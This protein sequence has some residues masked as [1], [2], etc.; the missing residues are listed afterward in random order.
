LTCS[1]GCREA[2]ESCGPMPPPSVRRYRSVHQRRDRL[3][4]GRGS[5]K[6][7]RAGFGCAAEDPAQARTGWLAASTLTSPV[8][9]SGK[10]SWCSVHQ[11]IG[12]ARGKAADPAARAL[13]DRLKGVP[14]TAN[15]LT[16]P[17]TGLRRWREVVASSSVRYPQGNRHSLSRKTLQ[18]SRRT[19]PLLRS[20]DAFAAGRS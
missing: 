11:A 9:G 12:A 6:G 3:A 14:A 8:P 5:R 2:Q 19:G 20:G 7:W 10:P 1:T 17:D 16:H 18:F 13:A 15:P 4:R